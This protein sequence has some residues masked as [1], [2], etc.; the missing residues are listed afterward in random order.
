MHFMALHIHGSSNPLGITGNV[1]RIPMHGYFIFKVRRC[2]LFL[3]LIQNS[4]YSINILSSLYLGNMWKH[5]L[6]R[7]CIVKGLIQILKIVI[8][9]NSDGKPKVRVRLPERKLSLSPHEENHHAIDGMIT[10]CIKLGFEELYKMADVLGYANCIIKIMSYGPKGL[11]WKIKRTTGSTSSCKGNVDR[12]FIVAESDK[13]YGWCNYQRSSI[14]S[15]QWRKS[16]NISLRFY[17]TK[18]GNHSNVLKK[19]D[20]LRDRSL[21]NPNCKIDRNLYTTFI[22]NKDLLRTAYDN[23]KSNPDMMTPG[24]KPTT[25][26]G[27]SEERFDYIIERLRNNSFQFTPAKLIEITKANNK[28]RPI[29]LGN[30][31]DKLVQ[32][33]MRIVLEAIFD[34]LFKNVSHG[35]R[36]NRSCHTALRYIFTNFK[37]CTWWIE[38]DIKAC[39]DKINHD[40][41]INILSE[42][43]ADQRFI[44]LIRKSLKAGYMFKYTRQTDIIGT[45]Q[46]SIISP[47]LANIYLNKLDVY[48]LKLKEDFD[49]KIISKEGYDSKY[50]SI[51][52]KLHSARIKGEDSKIISKYASQLRNY[53][54]DIKGVK[55]MKIMYVRYADDWIVAVNGSFKQTTDILNKIKLFCKEE[56]NL[57]VSEE[58]TKI[59][60][61]Y[62]DTI[63]FL[64]TNIKHSKIKTFS[65]TKHKRR[66]SGFLVLS[67]PMDRIKDKLT[68]AGFLHIKNNVHH[69]V[70][71]ISWIPLKPEQII[72]LANSIINGYLN[73]YSFVY[74]RGQLVSYI[75]YIIRDVVLRTLA[76]KYRLSTRSKVYNKFGSDIIIKDMVN[77]VKGKPKILAIM[78]K[79]KTY[80]LNLWDFK[81]SKTQPNTNIPSLYSNNISLATLLNDA[82]KICKS[83][84]RV[85][86]H[87]IRMMKDLKPIK[88]T[89][90]YLLARSN[91]KQ[92]SICREC[93][94]KYHNGQLTIPKH[95][96]DLYDKPSK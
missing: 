19:L 16:V 58:K 36:L 80:K 70:S 12:D 71:R 73:Y 66:N 34:P 81:I 10:Y 35:F 22:L 62:T 60:N 88:G 65:H 25:L 55:S 28:K 56:L 11:F 32:E 26:D 20:S 18:V 92:I 51:Q 72:N 96:T 2:V 1:D 6:N 77:R 79:P 43:I 45:P 76:H 4:K 17:S 21:N 50:R 3:E 48:I 15:T 41:L 40:K 52:H 29:M 86:R 49:S 61:S 42:K 24:I 5:L 39:F 31:E 74:N 37:G 30:P 90:D 67:A 84:Y 38:G 57:I 91:R 69:G 68:K 33:V 44:E 93:H 7:A 83:T 63:T 78:F 13:I 9:I 75:F 54:R 95:V 87:H 47:I 64:G 23:L 82:C 85:E 89:L 8:E 14:K 27:M 53:N 46:G 94:I 59:I